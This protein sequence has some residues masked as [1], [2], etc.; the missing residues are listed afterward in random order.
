MTAPLTLDLPCDASAVAEAKRRVIAF[1]AT[2]PRAEELAPL[3][4]VVLDEVLSNILSYAHP[5][6]AAGHRIT[7]AARIE[8]DTLHLLVGDDGV[9]FDPLALPA[10]DTELALEDRA[11]G[12][13][14][15]ML[16]QEMMDRV[17]YRREGGR[18]LLELG[19]AL[20]P[21]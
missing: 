15:I 21:A 1:L 18:N 8:D 17:A 11:V 2:E 5:D 7:L 16:V 9:A 6:G 14:G 12:G 4:A 10:P 19:K 20:P 3:L 13:L